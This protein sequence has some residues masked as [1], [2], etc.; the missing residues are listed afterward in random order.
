MYIL[1]ET[2]TNAL[3]FTDKYGVKILHKL[4]Q[5]TS[6]EWWIYGVHLKY[7]W[8]LVYIM[9]LIASCIS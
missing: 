5:N 7:I 4:E 1:E 9:P 2:I 8:I 3:E 6:H